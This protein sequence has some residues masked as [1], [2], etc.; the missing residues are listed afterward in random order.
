MNAIVYK[1][2]KLNNTA[3]QELNDFMDFLLSKQKNTNSQFILAYKKKILNVGV[4]SDDD[5]NIF[6]ENNKL[7]NQW[8]VPEW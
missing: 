7:L 1:Y 2:S 4:W 5:L 8:K 6:E 3:K